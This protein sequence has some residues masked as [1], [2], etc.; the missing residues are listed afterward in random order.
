[1]RVRS[2]LPG[3]LILVAAFPSLSLPAGD[4]PVYLAFQGRLRTVGG[5]HAAP[6]TE[7]TFRLTDRK[8]GGG[9]LWEQGPQTV[10]L[11]DGYF[12]VVL[13]DGSPLAMNHFQGERWLEVD[14]PECAGRPRYRVER[15][16]EAI[17]I[18]GS[19]RP[20]RPGPAAAK[21]WLRNQRLHDQRAYP[22]GIVPGGYLARA[23]EAAAQDPLAIPPGATI[24]ASPGSL[25]EGSWLAIGPTKVTGGQTASVRGDV[26]GRVNSIAV[27]PTDPNIA[28]ACGAQGGV[29]K[30]TNGGTSWTALSDNLPS[31]ATGAV[32]IAASSP[33]VLYLGTGEA[34]FSIDSY[35]GAGIFK[36]VD[37]GATWSPTGPI[38]PNRAPLNSAAIAQLV[39]HPTDPN[40]VIAAVGTFLEGNRL[41]SGGI[42]RSI[43]GGATWTRA[44]GTGLPT[45][46][47]AGS[48]VLYDP[49]DPNKVYAALG[50]V[51]GSAN[52][53]VYKSTNGGASFTKLAGGLPTTNV[54]RINLAIARSNALVLY[55]SV[56]NISTDQLLGI[57]RTGDGG[58]TWTQKNATGAGCSTQ[59]WYDMA[60]AVLPTDPNT[61]YF[62]GVTL[63]RST[64]GASMFSN[65]SLSSGT[66]GDLHAD[67]H[68]LVFS[69]SSTTQLWA[70]NDGGVWRTDN[71]AAALPVNWVNRNSN[72]ALLQFQSVA[73]PPADPNIVYGGTQDNGTN[74][75]TGS[76]VWAHADDGDGGQT[77]VDFVTP[78]TV[79]HTFFGVSFRRSDTSGALGSWLAKQNGLNTLDR[80]EFYV[81]V[82]MDP[83]N[84]AVLYLGTFRLYRTSS[85]GDSWA[86]ISPDL[87]LDPADPNVIGDITA[88]GVSRTDSNVIYVGSTSSQINVTSN[89]GGVWTNR[90]SPPLP[91]RQVLSLAVSPADANTAYAAY[92]GFDDPNSGFGHVFRTTD[93]GVTWTN[94]TSNLPNIPVS[95]ITIDPNA[96][97]MI[98]LATDLGPY[99]STN[100]G[101]TWRHYAGGLPNVAT[102]EIAVQQPNLLFT[103]SHGRGMFEAFGCTGAGTTDLD[104]DNVADFCDNCVGSAN[105]SQVDADMDGFGPPCD[106]ADAIAG[107]HPG[108]PP[109]SDIADDV[110]LADNGDL[111]WSGAS[112]AESYNVYR[113][114]IGP[115]IHFAFNHACLAGA[116]PGLTANDADVP[117]LN[118]AFY[119]LVSSRNCMAE[120]GLGTRS[121]GSPRPNASP[122]P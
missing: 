86:T 45:G 83:T 53:G 14:C 110:S 74:K 8:Y 122:C 17:A 6:E 36:S 84:A 20:V 106:C 112:L 11:I 90:K 96:P 50:Y 102:F 115:T 52:N 121:N 51:G 16:G 119:Y 87:T 33:G 77:A 25:A 58:T 24:E 81:P 105:A 35:W 48:D 22:T 37:S 73:V 9:V 111:T 117:A 60:L 107:I 39:V 82:E 62:G 78:S 69:P 108:A 95:Q 85:R 12:R 40:T 68:A 3:A 79:Y 118:N 1:M 30:T 41:F 31:L 5:P 2:L 13:G 47:V 59:C 67:Q 91:N 43:D 38:D 103:A 54:G 98:Y 70:G 99:A 71:A 44:L 10:A 34:N 61:V 42:Y 94:T 29:W 92:S 26:S 23:Y 19:E 89:L 46:A 57:W 97:Q 80:S 116:V 56:H 15:R 72:L 76:D 63:F 27:H 32:A 21:P 28:Y 18:V 114:D 101:Q 109:P 88:I 113:G 104:A 49:A 7:I 93:R 75:Y 64:N 55:A 4:E 100:G 65:A 66:T 120:S